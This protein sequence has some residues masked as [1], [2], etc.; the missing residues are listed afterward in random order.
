[1]NPR[2]ATLSAAILAFA[3]IASVAVAGTNAWTTSGPA[4]SF[5]QSLLAD[6]TGESS[7]FA[8]AEGPVL[9]NLKDDHWEKV[10]DGTGLVFTNLNAI[11][12][13]PQDPRR[14]YV[15]V[16]TPRFSPS[17]MGGL[18]RSTDGGQTWVLLDVHQSD[19]VFSVVVDPL[20]QA[21]VFATASVCSCAP[22]YYCHLFGPACSGR[23]YKSTDAGLTW[24]RQGNLVDVTALAIDPLVS[25][26]VYAIAQG[27]VVKSV[28]GGTTWTSMNSGLSNCPLELVVSP[29][30]PNV[31]FVTTRQSSCTAAVYKSTDGGSSWKPTALT[32]DRVGYASSI[33][34]D[35]TNEDILYLAAV[36]SIPDQTGAG[37]FRSTDGGKNWVRFDTGLPDP[38]VNH[39]AVDRDGAT[40]H[41]SIHGKGV[42][43]YT[44]SP[45]LR[46]RVRAVPR[47]PT[48]IP[49]R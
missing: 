21:T 40:L 25:T 8:G 39:V 36:G 18:Y 13:D 24:T 30:N 26:N 11:A 29:A 5:V 28:D 43:D 9:F 46:P 44:Y 45:P 32:F 14:I 19:P 31:L 27:A 17:Q 10:A 47:S 22:P 37:F 2:L 16:S 6:P 1:M 41:V 23:I 3:A 33:A 35:S 12:V 38:N 34:V 7:V 15:G 4:I 48:T 42:F 49:A 20:R